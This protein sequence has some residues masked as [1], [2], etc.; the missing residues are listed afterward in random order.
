MP[1]FFIK[2][3]TEPGN[4]V[5]DIFGGSGTTGEACDQLG[6][7]WKTI[8]FRTGV[9]R[10]SFFRFVSDG[11]LGGWELVTVDQRTG[12][13]SWRQMTDR[14]W[15][16]IGAEPPPAPVPQRRQDQPRRDL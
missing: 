15:R 8:D 2:F 7:S 3:L 4:A 9:V 1:E 14:D 6:R 12:K 10:A 16:E 13:P 5:A 11:Q